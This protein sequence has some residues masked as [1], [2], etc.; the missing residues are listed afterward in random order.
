MTAAVETSPVQRSEAG[1]RILIVDDDPLMRESLAHVLSD[2]GY[3]VLTAADGEEAGSLLRDGPVALVIT[4]IYLG[5][6]DGFALIKALRSQGQS[7][8]IIA[9]SGDRPGVDVFGMARA[10]G[11]DATLLKPFFPSELNALIERLL[12][13]SA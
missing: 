4:D 11:A 6:G 10:V 13:P 12:D 8:P 3:E 1:P 2:R 5:K 7:F 9:M